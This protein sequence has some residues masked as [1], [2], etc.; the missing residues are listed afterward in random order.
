MVP[1][2]DNGWGIYI[3]LRQLLV[4]S[5]GLRFSGSELKYMSNLIAEFIQE[6]HAF[7][8]ANITLKFHNLIHYPR[9]IEML[10]PLYHIWVMRGE[11]SPLITQMNLLD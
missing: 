5:C 2:K 3:L 4:F 9:T 10:G 1:E 7:F 11:A 8:K 6:Y